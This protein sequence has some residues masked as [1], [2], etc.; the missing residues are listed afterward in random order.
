MLPAAE[1]D[2]RAARARFQQWI[3]GL[4]REKDEELERLLQR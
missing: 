3:N 4:W 1:G 2:E